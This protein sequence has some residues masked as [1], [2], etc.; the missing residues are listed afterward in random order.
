MNKTILIL[1]IAAL[2][3]IGGYFI[4]QGGSQQ[5]TEE[6]TSVSEGRTTVVAK[7]FTIEGS[8]YSFNP[9]SISVN[10]GEQVR[11]I[12]KNVGGAVHNFVIQDLGIGTGTIGPGQ[13]DTVEFTAP[14]AGAYVFI[15]SVPG[16]AISGMSGDLLVE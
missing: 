15:C 7:E 9:D 11:V 13:T 16:H 5:A 2:T 14:I 1:I 4:L 6:N 12:F 8:E 3:G 10:A